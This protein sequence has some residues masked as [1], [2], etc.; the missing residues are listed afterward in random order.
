MAPE[1]RCTDADIDTDIAQGVATGHIHN[2]PHGYVLNGSPHHKEE[3]GQTLSE[4]RYYLKHHYRSRMHVFNEF[5]TELGNQPSS[6]FQKIDQYLADKL[7]VADHL[8]VELGRAAFTLVRQI[9]E[10]AELYARQAAIAAQ[11]RAGADVPD[12]DQSCCSP[13][14]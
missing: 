10:A 2:T 1:H 6:L 4:I 8:I 11:I 5:V 12:V 9:A 7:G 13:G 14:Q 3:L